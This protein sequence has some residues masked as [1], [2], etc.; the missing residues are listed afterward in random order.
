VLGLKL[1][2][3]PI[4]AGFGAVALFQAMARFIAAGF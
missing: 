1:L 3:E 4:L 2:R